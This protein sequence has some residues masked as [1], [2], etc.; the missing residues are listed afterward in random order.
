MKER[1]RGY[2]TARGHVEIKVKNT[3]DGLV[4]ARQEA[5]KTPL[6]E[7]VGGHIEGEGGKMREKKKKNNKDQRRKRQ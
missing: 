3:A 2:E 5:G 6:G 1:R 7:G 4:S